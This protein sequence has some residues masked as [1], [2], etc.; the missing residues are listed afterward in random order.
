MQNVVIYKKLTCK[1]TLRQVFNC[2]MPSQS[3][4]DVKVFPSGI[5]ASSCIHCCIMDFT[6]GLIDYIDTKAKFRHLKKLTCKGTL[7]QVLSEFKDWRD[8]QS[9]WYF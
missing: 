7:Q 3:W 4:S 1:G 6:Q 2:L 8:S 9:C 5:Q